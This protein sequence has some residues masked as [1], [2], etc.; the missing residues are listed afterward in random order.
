MGVKNDSDKVF[1]AQRSGIKSVMYFL[2]LISPGGVNTVLSFTLFGEEAKVPPG[3]MTTRPTLY[4]D[5]AR[6]TQYKIKISRY[7]QG[8]FRLSL[9]DVKEQK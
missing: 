5:V 8:E 1:S 2:K 6:R 3:R 7:Y 9:G 4:W